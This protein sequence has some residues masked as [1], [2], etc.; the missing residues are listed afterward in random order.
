MQEEIRGRPPTH[1]KLIALE[2]EKTRLEMLLEQRN[3]QIK[4]L[5]HTLTVKA[6]DRETSELADLIRKLI[7]AS[8]GLPE[9]D[10]DYSGLINVEDIRERTRLDKTTLIS[11]SAMRLAA[12]TFKGLELLKEIAEMEDPYFISEE[13]LGRIEAIQ[14]QQA[15]AGL[16]HAQNIN[17][18]G[19]QPQDN[20][21][22]TQRPPQKKGLSRILGG[23]L[24]R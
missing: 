16:D 13:G 24:K 19:Q 11:H 15:K 9:E 12:N 22:S 21:T 5:V 7:R 3:E 2:E 14:Q 1:Q 17:M 20:T 8:Q 18:Y 10:S 23:I 6:E 4:N